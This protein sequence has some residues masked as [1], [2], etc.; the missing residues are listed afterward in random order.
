MRRFEGD[1]EHEMS[2]RPSSAEVKQ[3]LDLSLEEGLLAAR[4]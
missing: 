3:E 4:I 1:A 2:G